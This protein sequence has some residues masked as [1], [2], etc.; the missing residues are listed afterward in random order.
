MTNAEA[1]C[2]SG[3]GFRRPPDLFFSHEGHG[4]GVPCWCQNQLVGTLV[5][6]VPLVSDVQ[7][8]VEQP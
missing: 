4:Q 1:I 3:E 6:V 7:I 2:S 5:V 8:P